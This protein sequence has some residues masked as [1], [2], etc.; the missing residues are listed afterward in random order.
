MTEPVSWLLIEPGWAVEA[1]DGKEAGTV[2]EVLG[3]PEADIFDGLAVSHGVL[4]RARYVPAESVGEITEGHVALT[5]SSDE[6]DRLGDYE[7]Q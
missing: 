6:F 4:H 7:P 2:R 3:D 5:L 1:N